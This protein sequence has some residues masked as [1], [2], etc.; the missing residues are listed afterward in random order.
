[1]SDEPSQGKIHVDSDWK[2]EAEQTKE[3]LAAQQQAAQEQRRGP[4]PKAGLPDLLNMIG[5]PAAMAIGGYQTPDGK[6]VPPDL[7][8]AKYHIDMLEVLE[9]KTQ[10]NLTEEE[11][12]L[13][14]G[15]LHQLRMQF[16]QAATRTGAAGSSPTPEEA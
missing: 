10:G 6:T 8:A 14:T 3:E 7:A 1:M 5:M 12:Q 4:L 15:V 13:L 11:G 9:A 2:L 16:T